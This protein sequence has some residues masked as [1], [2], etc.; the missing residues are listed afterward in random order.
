MIDSMSK[1]IEDL[2]KDANFA[3]I[4]GE[5]RKGTQITV[6]NGAL[7]RFNETYRA[8]AVARVLVGESWGQ[9]SS[10]R[11]LDSSGFA[12]LLSDATKMAKSC[13]K[14]SDKKLDL[15][16]VRGVEKR[17]RQKVKTPPEDVSAEEKIDLV[18]SLDK[19]M[20][21]D[22]KIINTNA[23]YVDSHLE[24]TLVNTAGSRLEWDEM[25]IAGVVQPVAREGSN[26]QFDYDAVDGLGG[27]EIISSIDPATFASVCAQGAVDLLSAEKPPSGKMT[28]VIDSAIAGLIAHEVC[29]HASEA[30]EVVKGRSFLTGKVGEEIGSEHVTMV[31]DG[32][33]KAERGGFPFDSEGT[34]ASRTVIIDKGVFNS[35]LHTL[36]TASIMDEKPTGNGRAQDYNRRIFARMTNTFFDKGDWSED[37][38]IED[39]K[40]GVYVIRPLSGMED[41]VGGGLQATALKGYEIKNGEKTRLLR[42]MALA[43]QVL[44]I[45]KTVD[46]A[47]KTLRFDGGTCGKGEEDFIPTS[48]GGPQMRAEMMIGGG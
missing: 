6:V 11:A 27:Y 48:T 1:A 37:E 45:L 4:R 19:A 21:I 33:L 10:S 43:G 29:G 20:K 46:A 8:G 28:V 35:Y 40:E 7:R 15:S 31:D 9:A 22:D 5:V 32:T 38:I 3:D 42:R 41:V 23:Q 17:F 34:P 24:F 12:G 44:E 39:T 47:G 16:H 36:E 18:M 13:A 14:Y 30:D 25:R 2:P 26:V